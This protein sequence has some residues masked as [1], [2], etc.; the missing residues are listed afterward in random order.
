MVEVPYSPRVARCGHCKGAQLGVD[1]GS[2]STGVDVD[3]TPDRI[4]CLV[5]A[6]TA[7]PLCGKDPPYDGLKSWAVHNAAVKIISDQNSFT[8]PPLN[9]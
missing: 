3:V 9:L 8:S 1:A 2:H 4:A 7:V 6:K 5:L